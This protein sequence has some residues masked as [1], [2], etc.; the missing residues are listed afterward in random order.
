[1]RQVLYIMCFAFFVF[2]CS[3]SD[4]DGGSII[5]EE[6]INP[7]DETIDARIAAKLVFPYKNSLCN[8]GI[9]LT[10]T[11]ST[12]FFEWEANKD[13]DGYTLIIENL[14]SGAIISKITTQ[15]KIAIVIQ[16]AT[17]YSWHVVSNSNDIL[18][19]DEKSETWQFYNAAPG[20][21]FYAPFPAAINSP[22]MAATIPTTAEVTLN[23]TGSDVDNDI[24]A[25]D[26]YFGV[27]S[28]P[29]FHIGGL[30]ASELNVSVLANT[31]YYWKV[32]TKDEEGN[33][34]DSGVHQFKVQ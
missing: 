18:I 2:G 7:D 1:M 30:T 10:P 12:V 16:R 17:P 33:S 5:T 31:I 26:V 9:N 11:E 8:E 28:E 29:E 25:Y 13:A 27:N 22:A 20:V 3:K 15:I 19:A 14:S 32:V 23:W 24:I 6:E 4:D 21:E 34:S